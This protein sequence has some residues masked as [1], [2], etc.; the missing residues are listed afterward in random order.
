MSFR[1]ILILLILAIF[2]TFFSLGQ[3]KKEW[4]VKVGANPYLWH[5]DENLYTLHLETEKTFKKSPFLTHGFG[6]DFINSVQNVYIY[7]YIFKGYPFFKMA[8]K[9]P[10]RYLFLGVGPLIHHQTSADIYPERYGPGISFSIGTQFVIK[11]KFTLGADF[12]IY[13]F[14][15][16]N[17]A[18][19]DLNSRGIYTDGIY[20]FKVGYI[21]NHKKAKNDP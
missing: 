2:P 17:D 15:N 4:I 7:K 21:I 9:R 6:F 20:S 14:K 8:G 13:G 11:D 19:Y 1:W 16:L 10:Y 18:A 5:S 12:F 3:S